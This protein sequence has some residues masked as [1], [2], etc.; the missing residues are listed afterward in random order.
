MPILPSGCEV[1]TVA[2]VREA[3][4]GADVVITVTASRAPLVEA[5]W[6]G[7]S[8]HVTAVGSDGPDKQELDVDVLARAGLVVA[9]SVAQ[10]ARIGEVHHAVAARV[11]R[12]EDVVELGAITAGRH[13]G[14]TGSDGLTVCDLTGVG[15]QDVAAA[16]LVMERA[17]DRGRLI[18]L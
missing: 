10:C 17:G 12:E 8:S 11:L 7:P 6:L 13:A 2:S 15:V 3:V 14:R 4:D 18:E 5:E 9:D 16:A 1:R